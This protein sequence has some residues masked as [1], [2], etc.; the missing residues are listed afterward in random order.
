MDG[1][2]LT[3]YRAMA[4]YNRWM[5]EKLYAL[6]GELPDEERKRPMGAFFGFDSTGPSTTCSWPTASG[7]RAS[8]RGPARP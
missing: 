4:R 6:A 7:W 3:H 1:A 5:N 8:G 2:L